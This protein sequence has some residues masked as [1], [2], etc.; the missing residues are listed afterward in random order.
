[1][2]NLVCVAV[3]VAGLISVP[4]AD[5]ADK[6]VRV[7]VE[8]VRLPSL[9]SETVIGT[10]EAIDFRSLRVVVN[11]E[12]SWQAALASRQND[13]A[14][15]FGPVRFEIRGKTVHIFA[16]G[17][18][19]PNVSLDIVGS[20]VGVSGTGY[21]DANV[22]FNS[23]APRGSADVW[24]KTLLV[25]SFGRVISTVAETSGRGKWH[26]L[27]HTFSSHLAMRGAAAIEIKELAGHQSIA[28]TNRYMHLAP[29]R[30]RTAMALPETGRGESVA[31]SS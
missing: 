26:R 6:T 12:Q 29:E 19:E 23:S 22:R 2:T 14:Q 16:P 18:D 30:R 10:W 11:K 25:Q 13:R 17:I 31:R 28:T 20:G 1:M 4:V 9:D 3:A 8:R 27:R 7:R 21:L 15:V 5:A 24:K